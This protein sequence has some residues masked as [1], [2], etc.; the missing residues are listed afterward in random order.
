MDVSRCPGCA[1]AADCFR[2]G[3]RVWRTPGLVVVGQRGESKRGERRRRRAEEEKADE[4]ENRI[5]FAFA[6]VSRETIPQ[7]GEEWDGGVG[8]AKYADPAAVCGAEWV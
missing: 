3:E 8:A 1:S 7:S 2:R 5:A 6:L 4:E